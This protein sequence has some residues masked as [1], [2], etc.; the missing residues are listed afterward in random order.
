MNAFA[1]MKELHAQRADLAAL[2]D[3]WIKL[4]ESKGWPQTE[5]GWRRYL[6]RIKESDSFPKRGTA[7]GQSYSATPE[8][9]DDFVSW[10]KAH[11]DGAG[12]ANARVAYNCA[13]YRYEWEASC[14]SP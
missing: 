13:R 11:E 5:E 12:G 10:W 6:V 14:R 3:G 9:P 8:P 2:M 4:S 1:L 7:R